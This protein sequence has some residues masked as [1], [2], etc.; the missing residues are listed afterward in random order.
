MWSV[1]M[2]SDV[3]RP[4]P[5][6]PKLNGL[7]THHSAAVSIYSG[8]ISIKEIKPLQA[9]T[10]YALVSFYDNPCHFFFFSPT[11]GRLQYCSG[12]QHHNKVP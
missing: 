9:Y 6:F 12:T 3:Y 2:I 7:H 11:S 10:D 5:E 1:A 4:F 8:N